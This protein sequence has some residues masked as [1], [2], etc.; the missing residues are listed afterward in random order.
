MAQTYISEGRPRKL[1][2]PN[3]YWPP[4]ANKKTHPPAVVIFI[5]I[6]FQSV[7]ETRDEALDENSSC[8]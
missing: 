6:W 8:L 3:G 1:A 4:L 2:I 7:F 5:E